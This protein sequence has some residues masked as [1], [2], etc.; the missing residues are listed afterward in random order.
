MEDKKM[1]ELE[2]VEKLRSRANVTYDEARDALRACD[3]DLL[4]AM[5]YLEKLGKV[6]APR[7]SVVTTSADTSGS[8][9][10]VTARVTS[11]ERKADANAFSGSF[12]HFVKTICQKLSDNFLRIEQDDKEL[13][14]APLWAVLIVFMI[15]NAFMLVAIVV[16]LFFGCRYSICG[17]DDLSKVNEVM[18]RFS[19]AAT[20]LKEGRKAENNEEENKED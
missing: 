10:D 18:G 20:T 2:K 14:T 5:V 11:S 16:S 17:K 13:L 3:G 1:D 12:G 15:T 7:Q 8:Y 6:D 19:D 9:Q 4:D